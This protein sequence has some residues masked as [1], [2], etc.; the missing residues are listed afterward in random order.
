M[1]NVEV[2]TRHWS[3]VIGHWS[4]VIRHWSF[5]IGHWS[6]TRI[7]DLKFQISNFSFQFFP[8]PSH[9]RS[10]RI[11]SFIFCRIASISGSPKAEPGRPRRW[12]CC[13]WS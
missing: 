9:L 2:G 4:L 3:L 5:V 12:Y 1:T 8:F 6:L 13:S 10:A 7:S 11:S